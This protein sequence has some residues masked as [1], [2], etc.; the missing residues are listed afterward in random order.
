MTVEQDDIIE[1]IMREGYAKTNPENF[2]EYQEPP[3][4]SE[5][6]VHAESPQN[7]EPDTSK[8]QPFPLSVKLLAAAVAVLFLI[9]AAQFLG[10]RSVQQELADTRQEL[11]QMQT[12]RDALGLLWL[13]DVEYA[14][15][16]RSR[17]Y[18]CVFALKQLPDRTVID[19]LPDFGY[20]S[21]P[22]ALIPRKRLE[23]LMFNL[24]MHNEWP[25]APYEDYFDEN[26]DYY[27][28]LKNTE[29]V[30]FS[31]ETWANLNKE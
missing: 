20:A 15:G 22:S 5:A 24:K 29:T 31:D 7:R 3:T 9:C 17:E 14:K 16:H 6:P 26:D 2:S 4:G 10:G 11:E 8:Q 13:A 23:E 12:Q 25:D 30:V 18:Q 21:N 19:S 1:Q 27:W 28:L